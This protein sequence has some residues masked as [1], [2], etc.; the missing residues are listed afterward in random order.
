[1][2]PIRLGLVGLGGMGK[3]H[4]AKENRL[5]EVRFVGVADVVRSAVD[6]ASEQYGLPGFH[7]YQDLIDRGGCEAI[8]IA[9]PHPFHAPIALYAIER[10]LHVLTE[11][12]IAVTVGEADAM[13]EAAARRGVKL[14][15]MFQ[16][17]TESTM[18]RAREL[19]AEGAVGRVY[20]S[21]VVAS[22]WFRTQAYYDSGAWRGTWQGEGGGI[23]MNQLPHTL[24][25]FIWLGGKPSGVTARATTRG[26][27]IEVE[28][29]I[30]ALLDFDG[31][32]SGC[33]YATTAEWPGE[34]R[35]EFTGDRGKLVILDR[36]LRLYRLAR[37]LSEEIATGGTWGKPEGAW[38]TIEVAP[39]TA[40]H[41]AVVA[42]FA[43]AV[44][45]GEP[46]VATGEDGLHA[47]ELA[48]ALMLSGFERRPVGL[49]LDRADYD[50]FLVAKRSEVARPAH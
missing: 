39:E 5:P 46:L 48:N 6:A 14:G 44:R 19:L 25:A 21:V 42:Q 40:G 45:L 3:S 47:L 15:V 38:E 28:D 31:D 33:F 49:P 37:T 11:K 12:P 36:Q 17:R 41:G 26:H 22:H 34:D 18:R 9:T 16:T 23:L 32:H 7:G 4:L 29:T 24:D 43:R 8:L 30:E 1:M 27:R 50:R 35:Y 20:R 2:E 10:G 13:V